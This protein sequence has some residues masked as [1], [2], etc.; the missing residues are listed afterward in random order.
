MRDGKAIVIRGDARALPLPDASVDLIVTSPPYFGLRS[1][2]DAGEHYEGQIGAEETPGE[3]VANLVECTREWMRVLKPEGSIFVNLG[4]KYAGWAGDGPQNGLQG[5]RPA[6]RHNGQVQRRKAKT[7]I[8]TK[9]LMG[10][11]WRYAN[12]CVDELGLILRRDLIWLKSN[13]LPESAADRCHT[14]HEYWFHLVKQVQYFSAMDELRMPHTAPGRVAGVRAFNARDKNLTRTGT[15][16]YTGQNPLGRAP[17]SVWEIATQPLSVPDYLAVD[18]FAAFPTAWPRQIIAGWCPLDGVVLDPFG[19]TGTT[20]LV[21]SMFG[22]SGISVDRSSDYC[23]IAQWR[24]TDPGE[25]ARAMEVRKPAPVPV[26]Q[27]SL[28][29]EEVSD[30]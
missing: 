18:H 7:S 6:N 13:G 30:A 11:P 24:T 15:G 2:Q 19:G 10:L 1:Y 4:D 9:S 29:D 16:R 23:R 20:A 21:A 28:F 22:R 17:G 25:R 26:G 12:A 5:G 27:A 14:S 3:Y 8:P